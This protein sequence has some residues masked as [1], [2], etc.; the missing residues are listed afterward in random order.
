MMLLVPL[1]GW[2]VASSMGCCMTVPGLPNID[3]LAAGVSTGSPLNARAAYHVH[4]FFVWMLFA[5]IALH[6]LAALYHHFIARDV[7]LIRMLPIPAQRKGQRPAH[8][9]EPNSERPE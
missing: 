9:Q 4:V 3:L 7:I 6:V 5:V 8:Q 1:T 2:I